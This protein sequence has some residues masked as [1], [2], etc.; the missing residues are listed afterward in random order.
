MITLKV[1]RP[2][3][4]IIPEW[5]KDLSISLK[6][7]I[8]PAWKM[9]LNDKSLSQTHAKLPAG[10]MLVD[11]CLSNFVVCSVDV[12]LLYASRVYVFFKNE[13]A[14][15]LL[16]ILIRRNEGWRPQRQYKSKI[17]SSSK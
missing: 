6:T 10:W 11:C 17:E 14:E 7:T 2:K 15:K 13:P 9:G 3:W 4:A 8:K 5:F 1:H 12:N 16:V